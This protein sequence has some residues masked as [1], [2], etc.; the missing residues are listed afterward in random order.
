MNKVL[1]GLFISLMLS[2]CNAKYEIDGDTTLNAMEGRMVYLQVIAENDLISLD[3]CVVKEG[4]FAFRG[5]LDTPA[6][7]CLYIND[8]NLVPMVLESGKTRVSLQGGLPIV[9]GSSL[10]NKLHCFLQERDKLDRLLIDLSRKETQ[11]IMDGEDYDA[12]QIRLS[13]EV[14]RIVKEDEQ[15]VK[16]FIQSNYNNVLGPGAFMMLTSSFR[17]PISTPQIEEI[18]SKATSYFKENENVQEFMKAAEDKMNATCVKQ[19]NR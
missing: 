8:E 10:N 2:S 3:S 19:P 4:K 12:I 13:E 14:R 18:M 16:S 17:Y 1:V 11:M 6:M 9:K 15:L 7:G 5:D